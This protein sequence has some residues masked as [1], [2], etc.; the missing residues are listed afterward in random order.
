M[1]APKGSDQGPQVNPSDGQMRVTDQLFTL[2]VSAVSRKPHKGADS[3]LED[4]Y[5]D[6]KGGKWFDKVRPVRK[7]APYKDDKDETGKNKSKIAKEYSELKET[8]LPYSVVSGTWNLAH[9]HADG[10]NHDDVPCEINGLLTPS[11]I[12]LLDLDKL[13]TGSRTQSKRHWTPASC[14]GPP[15][16]GNPPAAMVYIFSPPSTHRRPAKLK[17]TGL[18]LP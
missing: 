4:L 15:P 7:L 13:N 5:E 2:F 9:R 1:S 18:L 14:H 17:A 11:G 3:T 12:R 10:A 16:A 8:S 6:I